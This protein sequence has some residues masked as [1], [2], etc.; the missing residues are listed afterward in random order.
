MPLIG[1]NAIVARLCELQERRDW[2]TGPPELCRQRLEHLTLKLS[3]GALRAGGHADPPEL[4]PGFRR[5]AMAIKTLRDQPLRMSVR[6]FFNTAACS[7]NPPTAEAE[8]CM[9]EATPPV[10]S[11]TSATLCVI[12]SEVPDCCPAAAAMA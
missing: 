11:L 12:C 2:A 7:T 1:R 8:V 5:S 3:T 9:A 6:T 4:F 10:S